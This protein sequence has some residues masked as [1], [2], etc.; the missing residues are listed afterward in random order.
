VPI[1]LAL[2][3]QADYA[4][5]AEG[6]AWSYRQTTTLRGKKTESR[7]AVFVSGRAK[8]GDA[9]GFVVEGWS[10]AARAVLALSDDGLR[11]LRMDAEEQPDRPLF[12]KF[13]LKV[14]ERWEAKIKTGER[15]RTAR[16]EI[17]AEEEVKVPAGAFKAF[18]IVMSSEELPDLKF[19]SWFARDFGQ[20]KSRVTRPDGEGVDELEKF[21]KGRVRYRCAACSKESLEQIGCCGAPMERAAYVREARPCRCDLV[22][23]K[24]KCKCPHCA[25]GASKCYCQTGGCE[26]GLKRAACSCAHC[27]G[28]DGG[29][30]GQGGCACG[31]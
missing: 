19:E 9:E 29:E 11:V 2:L 27:R 8:V 6:C 21:E 17:A 4:P 14:G 1:L 3:L 20:I 12:L 7:R 28:C 31:K 22:H 25:A 15:V 16:F 23:G 30:D 26:C 18:K 24:G 13:P 5:L 10:G